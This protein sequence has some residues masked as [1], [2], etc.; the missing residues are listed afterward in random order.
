[1]VLAVLSLEVFPCS[2]NPQFKIR[3]HG[4][5]C[6]MQCKGAEIRE[7]DPTEGF[8]VIFVEPY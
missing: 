6:A 4:F 5:D 3:L 7:E 8:E 1:M 2:C